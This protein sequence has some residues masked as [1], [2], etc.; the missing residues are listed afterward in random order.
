M[1]IDPSAVPAPEA[2]TATPTPDEGAFMSLLRR[3]RLLGP[4]LAVVAFAGACASNA[5]QD[6]L[7]P[8]GRYARDIDRLSDPIFI[9]AGV[10]FVLV[11][12]GAVLIALRF[13]A[14]G[15]EHF[16]DMPSQIHGHNALE[17]GWTLLPAVVLGLV[18]VASVAAIFN[19]AEEPPE[20]AVTV[21]VVGNQWWWE[22]RYD[23]NGNG[24]YSDPEDVVTANDL[25]IP[26]GQQVG[27][28]ITSRDVIHSFWAPK[29]NGKRDAVPNRTHPWNLQADEP[30]EFIGQ[31]TEY[32]GLSHAEMRLKVV[33]LDEADFDAWIAEQQRDAEP[34]A[35]GD[36]SLE[37]LGYQVFTQ[38]LCSSCHQIDGI[39]EENFS[40]EDVPE[41][42]RDIMGGPGT[43]TDPLLQA[44][45]HAP[46]LTHLMS[47]TTFAGGKFDLVRD[48]E[49]C[50]ALGLDWAEDPETRDRCLDRGALEAW[51]RNPPAEKAMQAEAVPGRSPRRGMPALDLTEEQID[52]LVSYLM[53]LT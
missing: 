49:E 53:T 18:G 32:C 33:A 45:R 14:R 12:G 16:E 36:E 42:A 9:V 13:R 26:A 44:S 22:Y 46:N 19:L 30:G 10:V 1:T 17:I 21:Q 47:R 11:L 34:Y 4:A 50:R 37:A 52:Q 8:E 28:E 40:D 20:D 51:L 35:E 24:S 27:L 2:E 7:E 38:Q 29:L 39:N 43:I 23:V 48:T 3:A 5:P 15:Q 41:F 25:V 31:C 6:T